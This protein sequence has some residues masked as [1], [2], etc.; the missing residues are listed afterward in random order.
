M[1]S[2]RLTARCHLLTVVSALFLSAPVHTRSSA[3]KER[4][5]SCQHSVVIG[6]MSYQQHTVL[7]RQAVVQVQLRDVSKCD[8]TA[9]VMLSR[10]MSPMKA[11]A[12]LRLNY[13]PGY[14][15]ENFAMQGNC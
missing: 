11:D 8:V 5:I 4:Q 12:P 14:I 9:L 6:R 1:S 7:L 3:A 2:R 10:P 13:A 15:K